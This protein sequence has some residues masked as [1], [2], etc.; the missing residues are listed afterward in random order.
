MAREN[1]A[2]LPADRDENDIF[3]LPAHRKAVEAHEEKQRRREAA[4]ARLT[5]LGGKRE[6]RDAKE[7]WDDE[8]R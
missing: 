3:N 6:Y 5:A 8:D 1:V 7:D 4:A 2:K